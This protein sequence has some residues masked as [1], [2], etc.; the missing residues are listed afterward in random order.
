MI[1]HFHEVSILFN[2]IM[3]WYSLGQSACQGPKTLKTYG[4]FHVH[5]VHT[6]TV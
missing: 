3:C 5:D 2:S 1:I 4:P 6:K